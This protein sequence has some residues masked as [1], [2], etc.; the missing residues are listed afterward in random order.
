MV[1]WPAKHSCLSLGLDSDRSTWRSPSWDETLKELFFICLQEKIIVGAFAESRIWSLGQAC[2]LLLTTLQ[3]WRLKLL[4]PEKQAR[5]LQATLVRN[6]DWLTYLLTGVRCRA[7]SVAKKFKNLWWSLEC[8]E[9]SL[10]YLEALLNPFFPGVRIFLATCLGEVCFTLS[11]SA[12]F[13][14]GFG[15]F[16]FSTRSLIFSASFA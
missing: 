3:R 15:D 1:P 11:G 6:Y 14:T 2:S 12:S 5:K 16:F 10:S 9:K 13:L 7:T 8:C 4:R